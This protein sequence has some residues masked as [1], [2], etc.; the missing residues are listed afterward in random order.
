MDAST[1]ASAASTALRYQ[2]SVGVGSVGQSETS[3]PKS[4]KPRERSAS[5]THRSQSGNKAYRAS[6]RKSR[7][8]ETNAMPLEAAN[9]EEATGTGDRPA[10]RELSRRSKI[11]RTQIASV[12]S[13]KPVK[14]GSHRSQASSS[15]SPVRGHSTS[16]S[17]ERKKPAG[18]QVHRTAES[19]TLAL[20]QK[21]WKTGER[22][23]SEMVSMDPSG[24][25]SQAKELE[26]RS[27]R[28]KDK[29]G[30]QNQPS[31]SKGKQESSGT[32][33]N[34]P[35]KKLKS[36]LNS[37]K[38]RSSLTFVTIYSVL[39]SSLERIKGSKS[40]DVAQP[41]PQEKTLQVASKPSKRVTISGVTGPSGKS[42]LLEETE[43]LSTAGTPGMNEEDSRVA[44]TL[45]T[46]A[47][48]A[49]SP[50]QCHASKVAEASEANT[51]AVNAGS[52]T[53]GRISRATGPSRPGSPTTRKE[54][55]MA[56]SVTPQKPSRGRVRQ[57]SAQVKKNQTEAKKTPRAK[58]P[59]SKPS[60]KSSPTRDAATKRNVAGVP[61]RSK[62]F[63]STGPSVVDVDLADAL[64]I[65]GD[66]SG[67][68]EQEEPGVH[69]QKRRRDEHWRPSS[70]P[71]A[72]PTKPASSVSRKGNLRSKVTRLKNALAA[73]AQQQ[74][75]TSPRERTS[76]GP[77]GH[78]SEEHVRKS[79]TS[80][81][82]A[83]RLKSYV[84]LDVGH[85]RT[86]T[87]PVV[88]EGLRINRFTKAADHSKI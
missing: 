62:K 35:R 30:K 25:Q 41:H 66:R 9:K 64:S 86:D 51:I 2:T 73:R 87:E 28:D 78:V 22:G 42:F 11:Y 20:S 53:G 15:P 85:C 24:Q 63:I 46:E 23:P 59:S 6:S 82:S 88:M 69:P 37:A 33:V 26:M 31:S 72:E 79:K 39:S 77:A 43:S 44:A 5:T 57:P 21:D 50:S 32:Q 13:P 61:P 76:S 56:R 70:Q 1:R 80:K 12:K 52:S 27:S 58:L 68:W 83:P 45:G 75:Q 3:W 34:K 49:C 14:A 40:K 55:A 17:P 4:A 74:N 18:S 67:V 48:E 71:S 54:P 47:A 84:P 60:E 29:S 36:A 10:S 16:W 8:S 7:T 19:A 38:Q 81:K 65:T